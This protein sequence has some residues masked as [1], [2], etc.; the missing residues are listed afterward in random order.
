MVVRRCISYLHFPVGFFKR[1][2]SVSWAKMKST[3]KA[4]HTLAVAL[5]IVV[6]R[7][8]YEFLNVI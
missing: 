5:L 2:K 7:I 3:A 1:I 8:S 6:I 4:V